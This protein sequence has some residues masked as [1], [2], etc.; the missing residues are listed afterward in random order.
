MSL[1]QLYPHGPIPAAARQEAARRDADDDRIRLRTRS[2]ADAI[3]RLS[4]GD[5]SYSDARMV[6]AALIEA[7]ER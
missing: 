1:E 3:H 5:G 4:R 2:L 6:A 7:A